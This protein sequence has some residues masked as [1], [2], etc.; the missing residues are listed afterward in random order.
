M[1]KQRDRE[2]FVS[3][4][5]AEGMP[6]DVCR[7]VMRLGA[8]LHRLAELECSSEAA[9][10]DRVKCPGPGYLRPESDGCLC[11][12]YGSYDDMTPDLDE[13]KGASR[14]GTVPRIN[15]QEASARARVEALCS[16]YGIE[17]DFQGDP[18]GAVVKLKVPSGR[19][20]DWGRVGVC[21]P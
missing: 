8:T 18:R 13:L 4:M 9:D 6:L 3:I 1:S 19:T 5:V 10:R 15:V 16:P 11:R 2:E 17:P 14:H 7:Q 21:V 12:D 20:N